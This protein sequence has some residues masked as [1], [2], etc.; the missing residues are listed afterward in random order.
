MIVDDIFINEEQ[1][2]KI[3]YVYNYNK[4]KEKDI[5]HVTK[6][7]VVLFDEDEIQ[8]H[9]LNG[10]KFNMKEY[11]SKVNDKEAYIMYKAKLKNLEKDAKT[12]KNSYGYI[13]VFIEL[14]SGSIV[15]TVIN[16]F[17]DKFDLMHESKFGR[18]FNPEDL[19]INYICDIIFNNKSK[20][21]KKEKVVI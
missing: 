13:K 16:K 8:V 1:I 3:H 20:T 9:I 12:Y 2:T 7:K 19:N 15:E 10:E 17:E 18:I 11:Y 21:Y 4:D 5:Y 14:S 6:Y